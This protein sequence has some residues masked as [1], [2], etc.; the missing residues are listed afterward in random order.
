MFLHIGSSRVVAAKEII[1]IFDIRIKEKQS[2]R[3]FL[4]S[5]KIKADH[6]NDEIKSFI[7]TK[8]AVNFSP[9]AAMTLK[10]R[11]QANIFDK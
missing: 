1:G 5:A 11:Y 10:K 9:I 3:E 4:Q 2:T 8:A 6:G 7:V